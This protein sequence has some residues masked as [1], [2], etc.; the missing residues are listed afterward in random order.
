MLRFSN[1]IRKKKDFDQVFKKGKA[2]YDK[3]LG[4]KALKSNSKINRFGIIV[5]LKISKKAVERNLI[6]RR[7]KAILNEEKNKI[8]TGNDIV[9]ISLPPIKKIKYFEIKKSIQKNFKKLDLY[10]KLK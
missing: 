3:F 9:I 5:G 10:N 4:V 8:K 7:I 1:R 2:A 6:K